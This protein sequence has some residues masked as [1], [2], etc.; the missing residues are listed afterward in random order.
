MAVLRH[1]VAVVAFPFT[2]SVLVPI[3]VAREYGIV[4]GAPSSALGVALQ[5]AGAGVVTAGLVLFAASLRRFAVE[6]RG[7]LAPWD[8]PKRLVI[9]GPYRY[10]RNPMISGVFFVLVG[11]ALVLRSAPHAIWSAMFLAINLIYIPLFEEPQLAGRFG[12]DYREYCQHV[13][14]LLPTRA[15]WPK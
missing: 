2:M 8:P 11:E 3:W 12:E 6:G 1:G 14:R 13:P 15:P 7:T 5:I 9:R 4:L 10:V